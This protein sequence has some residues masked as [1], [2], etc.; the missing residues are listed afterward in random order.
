VRGGSRERGYNVLYKEG[1]QDSK[2]QVAAFEDTWHWTADTQAQFD[3]LVS[4]PRYPQKVADVMQGMEKVVGHN[5]VLAYLTMMA[6]RLVELSRV[7]KEAGSLYLHCDPAAS[8]YLKVVLDAVFGPKNFRGEI[9]WQRSSAHNDTAQGLKQPGRIHDV[10]LFYTKSD[11]WI[12]RPQFTPYSEE[13]VRE[14]F[15]NTDAKGSYKDADLSAA[16]P[17]GD[18]SY[19][20]KVKR[21]ARGEWK[22]DLD[23]EWQNPHEGWEYKDVPPPHGRYWAY[24][25]EN[26]RRFAEEDRIHYFGTG[27]PRLKQYTTDMQGIGLQ[28]VWTDIPPINARAQE[29]LGYPTQKPE[30]LLDRIIAVSS[31][32]GDW[33]L[34]PFGGCGTTAASSEKLDRNWVII[35]I[36]TLAINLVKRR[37]EKMYPD[38]ALAMTVEGYPADLAGALE[39]FHQDP[40]EFEYWCCDMVNARPAGDKRQGKMKGADRGIDGVITF[41]D[42]NAG[43]QE[44]NRILVQVKGGHLSSPQT[45]DFRGT[46]ER[47]KAAGG[48]FISLE[49]PTKPMLHE[50]VEAGTFTYQMTGQKFPV[51]QFLAQDV[52]DTV[53]EPLLMLDATLRVR[54]ANRAFYQTFHVSG[55]RD[56]EPAHLRAGQR[57]VGH[58]R[59]RTLLE[60]IV[61]TSSVFNDFELEH[62]FPSIGRRVM[63][64]NGEKLHARGVTRCVLAMEDVTE[65]RRSQ[66][67]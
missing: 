24:S 55:R 45:R 64:L 33:V 57:P 35:D 22:S 23:D 27:T 11:Q 67:T 37:I 4:D 17:G 66:P 42:T 8:H 61:P 51:M 50:A 29:R 48:V 41:I 16:R 65:R 38:K 56:R 2:A 1:L 6:V 60:D 13:Y 54:S 63:L 53:R 46:I 44:Y 26:M 18:T 58:P 19:M 3:E 47:E 15:S 62:D 25:K 21:L 32:P 28:D 12:W 9:I 20:W 43:K 34:D 52:F 39:L 10:I 49:A 36:T 30:A 59:L 5:D 14:R 31:N 7:L 40:F